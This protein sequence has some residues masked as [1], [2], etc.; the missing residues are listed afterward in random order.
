MTN[1][2]KTRC[3]RLSLAVNTRTGRICATSMHL[4]TRLLPYGFKRSVQTFAEHCGNT[5]CRRKN[6]SKLKPD[7]E[8]R[9]SAVDK[10]PKTSAV[11]TQLPRGNVGETRRN[12]ADKKLKTDF[13]V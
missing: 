5:G 11:R 12:V 4:Q 8:K 13:T 2:V 10:K 1:G 3:C 9:M 6:A 7:S